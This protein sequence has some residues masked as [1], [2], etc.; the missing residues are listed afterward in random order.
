VSYFSHIHILQCPVT[1]EDLLEAGELQLKWVNERQGN[2]IHFE[3]G[4]IN[5]SKQIFYPILEDILFLLPQQGISLTGEEIN[6]KVSFD[7]QRIFN[8]FKEIGYDKFEGQQI[9]ED[10]KQFI[11]F[12][13]FLQHYTSRGFAKAGYYL[14]L[15]GNYFV[16]VASGPVAFKE[17]VQ[18]AK[19]FTCRIC[20]DLSLNALQ[21]AKRNL[22]ISGQNSLLICADMLHLPL[23]VNMADAV[24]CQHA[25]F[26]VPK[27]QQLDAIH[28]MIRIANPGAPVAIVYD[29]FYHSWL[30]NIALGPVQLYRILRHI[31][32]K[33][34]A[35]IFRKNKLYFYAH[36]PRWF[37]RNNP[38]K[39]IDFFTWRSVNIYF[40]KIYFHNNRVGKRIL[41]MIMTLEQ[42]YPR[43]MGILGEYAIILIHK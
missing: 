18:L 16:D 35:R 28:Q 22:A 27:H 21:Q 25:L 41:K 11:D 2:D 43:Q 19:G 30:M 10:A 12:R 15:K 24:L 8:Y 33:W 14:P 40:S 42:K 36:S 20:I 5:D 3:H 38:G 37:R 13:P 6:E 31:A 23:K 17:Y 34:Y 29:W 9:Y 32:G 26:H 1:G 4:L 7:R 39:K